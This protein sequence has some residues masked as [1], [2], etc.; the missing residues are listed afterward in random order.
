MGLTLDPV[1]MSPVT[2]SPARVESMT[3]N[4]PPVLPV[5]TPNH[6][7]MTSCIDIPPFSPS[8]ASWRFEA[9]LYALDTITNHYVYEGRDDNGI[10]AHGYFL[11]HPN[12]VTN[13]PG[14]TIFVNG[15]EGAQVQTA[16]TSH[17]RV[18]HDSIT[19]ARM[20][21]RIGAR[22]N[23]MQVYHGQIRNVRITDIDDPA[24]SRHYPLTIHSKTMPG[25][26]EVIDRLDMSPLIDISDTSDWQD[27]GNGWYRSTFDGTSGSSLSRITFDETIDATASYTHVIE[28]EGISGDLSFGFVYGENGGFHRLPDGISMVRVASPSSTGDLWVR[29]TNNVHD[30]RIRVLSVRKNSTSG[31][32]TGFGDQT[33]WVEV[34]E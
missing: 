9:D 24:N 13:S 29:S 10:V 34:I 33:P 22:Y 17:V 30:Y 6:N 14:A 2:L 5:W 4:T 18:V 21:R 26:V 25:T 16:V 32:M 1:S 23:G 15:V 19:D 12:G 20:L 3:G 31:Q 28:F 8:G 7:N 11:V 27:E